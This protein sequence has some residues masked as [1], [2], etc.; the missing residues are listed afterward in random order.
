MSVPI[1][2]SPLIQ[3]GTDGNIL[4]GIVPQA[5]SAPQDATVE[6]PVS[7]GDV[8]LQ[9]LN[10]MR[11]GKTAKTGDAL[12]DKISSR[13][14]QSAAT[15]KTAPKN[16]KVRVV[17]LHLKRTR[18]SETMAKADAA[19]AA[20]RQKIPSAADRSA[21][22][23]TAQSVEPVVRPDNE[24]A[25]KIAA[26]EQ[27][28]VA[29]GLVSEKTEPLK[30]EDMTAA[31]ILL[32]SLLS[33]VTPVQTT[34]EQTIAGDVPDVSENISADDSADISRPQSNALPDEKAPVEN[35][36]ERVENKK[37]PAFEPEN[38]ALSEREEKFSSELSDDAV[39]PETPVFKEAKTDDAPAESVKPV[40]HKHIEK[41]KAHERSAGRSDAS[42]RNKVSDETAFAPKAQKTNDSAETE[43]YSSGRAERQA[44]LLAEKL[45]VE[46]A[47][48]VHVE[49]QR[50]DFPDSSKTERKRPFEE[51][52]PI[53]VQKTGETETDFA[54]AFSDGFKSAAEP[55]K[56]APKAVKA[57]TDDGLPRFSEKPAE[58]MTAVPEQAPVVP[59]AQPKET[60]VRPAS[61]VQTVRVEGVTVL[62]APVSAGKG[63][64]VANA[65]PLPKA[66]TPA[67]EL[68]DQI[69][70]RIS[71]AVKEGIDKIEIVL[72]PKELGTIRVRLF[73]GEDGKTTVSLTAANKDTLELLQKEATFLKQAL[74][75]AGMNLSDGAFAFSHRGEQSENR[76]NENSARFLH[77]DLTEETDTLSTEEA[78]TPVSGNHALNI[79]V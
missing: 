57:A 67:N 18:S 59:D 56:T 12:Y 47:V 79:K 63:K 35:G 64:A 9:M 72:K 43:T 48:A 62:N 78:P 37:A 38:D 6:N 30:T 49:T 23:I 71:K 1:L 17:K 11:T 70:V 75:D 65:A 60:D 31:D 27:T 8:F 16:E 3:T 68:V 7:S 29:E 76:Q 26:F 15:A 22:V 32:M 13:A 55:E 19:K 33:P 14:E 21:P 2:S 46:T 40:Y 5:V 42:P 39:A 41:T 54:P 45:P 50:S 44:E 34:P 51:A 69:K 58:E 77:N 10:H 74:T 28:Q 4:S 52:R 25:E 53:R 61:P 73:V 66:P 20:D 36:V 24:Q